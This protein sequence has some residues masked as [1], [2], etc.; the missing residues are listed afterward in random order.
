MKVYQH[1]EQGS[2]EWLHLRAGKMTASRCKDAKDYKQLTKAQEKEGRTRGDPSA[3]LLGYAAQVAVERIAGRPI[4]QGFESWQMREGH[5]QEPACRIAYELRTGETVVETG[6]IATDD[7]L[8]LYSPDGLVGDDGLIEIKTLLS[9]DRICN[10]VGEGDISDFI[11][12]CNFGLWLTGRQWIDLC[13]W[14]P[15]LAEI[16]LD[17]TV[18]RIH[19]EEDVIEAMERDLVDFANMVTELERKL[20][21]RAKNTLEGKK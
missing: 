20:I 12:Q 14:V 4:D 16:G 13:I 11:D 5:V 6:A 18:H 17:L 7:E 9:A 8:F 2:E 1:I 3:K 10:I 21:K 15:A 19:R